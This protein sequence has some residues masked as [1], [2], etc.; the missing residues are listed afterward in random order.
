MFYKSAARESRARR[1]TIPLLSRETLLNQLKAS[2]YDG[3]LAPTAEG[4]NGLSVAIPQK[5]S[6]GGSEHEGGPE[7]NGAGSGSEDDR[8]LGDAEL[9]DFGDAIEL[10]VHNADTVHAWSGVSTWSSSRPT[11]AAPNRLDR[12]AASPPVGEWNGVLSSC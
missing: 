3:S 10:F 2:R 8:P 9:F 11:N 12:S 5:Y 7:P 6:G 4:S 1:V